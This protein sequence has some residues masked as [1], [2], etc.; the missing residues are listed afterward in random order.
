MFGRV[1][2]SNAM[3]MGV[4]MPEPGDDGAF[5]ATKGG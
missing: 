1:T 3:E 4:I 2:G 5:V